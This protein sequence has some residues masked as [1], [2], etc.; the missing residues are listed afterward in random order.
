MTLKELVDESKAIMKVHPEA[1]D[2]TIWAL[3]RGEY[4]STEGPFR[5]AGMRF[6]TKHRPSRIIMEEGL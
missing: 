1:G 2:A 5:M 3:I 4:G 6:D